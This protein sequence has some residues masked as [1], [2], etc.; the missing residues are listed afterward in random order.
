MR[1]PFYKASHKAWYVKD[2]NGTDVKLAKGDKKSTE[3]EAMIAW[4]AM[5]GTAEPAA[6][7]VTGLT[8][9]ELVK[10]WLSWVGKHKSKA[11]LQSYRKYANKWAGFTG[12]ARVEHPGL[13]RHAILR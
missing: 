12:H 6:P 7:Q 2:A 1:K 5:R 9:A 8:L 13:S 11:T 3:S 10:E 4:A